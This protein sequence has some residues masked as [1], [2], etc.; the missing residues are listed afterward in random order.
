MEFGQKS[1]DV[2]EAKR[3]N[4][5]SQLSHWPIQLALLPPTAPYLKEAEILLAADCVPFAYAGFHQDF[6]K[7][8]VVLV[9][10]PKLDDANFYIEISKI[11]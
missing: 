6:L 8:K 4:D 7:N 11:R 2:S 9:G 3:S 10:C 1:S 5:E